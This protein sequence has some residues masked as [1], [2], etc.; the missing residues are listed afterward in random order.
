MKAVKQV[1]INPDDPNYRD[2][3]HKHELGGTLGMTIGGVAGGIAAGAAAG[4]AIGGIA[5][6]IGAVAGAAI[7]GAIGGSAGEEVAREVNPTVEEM[8]WAETYHTRPYVREESNFETYRP[9]YRYG[10]ET[11]SKYRTVD[12][13]FEELE[14]NIKNNW[15]AAR[16]TSDLEWEDAR[17]A[18]RDA[19]ERLKGTER[20]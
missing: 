2:P 13:S 17:E 11:Y 14:P 15:G 7:G 10:I 4:A 6:P 1:K 9:A 16:G 18:A 12:R 8:Y 5:G 20:R 3:A 19:F